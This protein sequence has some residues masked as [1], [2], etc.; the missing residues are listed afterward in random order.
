MGIIFTILGAYTT[1]SL[2][3]AHMGLAIFVIIAT[4]YQASSLNELFKEKSGKQIKDKWQ[5][6]INMLSSLVIIGLFIYSFFA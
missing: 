4:L 1:Y 6:Y 5:T 3:N 2:W